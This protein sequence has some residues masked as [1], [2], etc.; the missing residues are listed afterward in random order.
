MNKIIQ[1]CVLFSLVL[2]GLFINAQVEVIEQK[3]FEHVGIVTTSVTPNNKVITYSIITEKGEDDQLEIVAYDERLE[4]EGR[5][6]TKCAEKNIFRTHALSGTGE[7]YFSL[8]I[9][10]GR[11][12]HSVVFNTSTFT[13]TELHVE[14][15]KKF[16][17]QGNLGILGGG[18]TACFKN[19]FFILGTV[20]NVPCI[21]VYNM[22]TGTQHVT[23]IPGLGKK[24]RVSFLGSDEAAPS[25]QVMFFN[26]NPKKIDAQY[27]ASINEFGE[28]ENPSVSINAQKNKL[29][30]DGNVTWIDEHT[31][32][33]C[34]ATGENSSIAK[35]MYI[36]EVKDG[37]VVR[38]SDFDFNDFKDF[39]AQFN[40]KIQRR[41]ERKKSRK[42]NFE[43]E[44]YMVTH[45]VVFNENAWTIVGEVF[46]PT[47][48]Q[49]YRTTYVNGK[50]VMQTVSVFD[51][52]QYTNAV[53][54]QVSQELEKIKD[55]TFSLSISDKPHYVKE[56][57]RTAQVGSKLNFYYADKFNFGHVSLENGGLEES[58]LIDIVDSK[59]DMKESEKITSLLN[60]N[61]E[62]WYED[63]YLITETFRSKDR[64]ESVGNKRK[65]FVQFKKIK[66]ADL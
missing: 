32:L 9:D 40:E 36:L 10:K 45:P 21:L 49:E 51:G 43:S 25:L 38:R 39:Y 27:I 7:F 48:R 3:R 11:E 24:N 16:E 60:S 41:I 65:E 28:V 55:Y 63:F 34:G 30:I 52:F 1:S 31:S 53:V 23:F 14:L 20:K 62:Y 61:V 13:G 54:L 35:G 42:K 33:I 26:Y 64:D 4:E 8:M 5:F 18:S 50:P 37:Q 57:I 58:P 12:I 15:E 59:K 6:Q 19:K 44:C 46:Y 22:L 47:Y 29:L 66:I 56:F 17:P 2:N